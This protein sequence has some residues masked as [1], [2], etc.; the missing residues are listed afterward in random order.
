MIRYPGIISVAIQSGRSRVMKS[1]FLPRQ[2][3]NADRIRFLKVLIKNC[4]T[5]RKASRDYSIG[6][7]ISPEHNKGFSEIMLS[8]AGVCLLGSICLM[9]AIRLFIADWHRDCERSRHACPISRRY[10]R[11]KLPRN[12]LLNVWQ[13]SSL[14]PISGSVKSETPALPIRPLRAGYR[15]KKPGRLRKRNDDRL[16]VEWLRS[17][18][19]I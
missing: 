7:R 16:D 3:P 8:L 4:T 17:H 10:N 9:R 14:P 12:I 19:I 5:A 6:K 1:G 13:Y 18:E 15:P 2:R 11:C